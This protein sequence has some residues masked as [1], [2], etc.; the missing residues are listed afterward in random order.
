[1]SLFGDRETEK[2]VDSHLETL[3]SAQRWQVSIEERLQKIEKFLLAF[4]QPSVNVAWGYHV[5]TG[6]KVLITF[7]KDVDDET[8]ANMQEELREWFS[9]GIDVAVIAGASI[10]V[11][12]PD[13]S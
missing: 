2:H 12:R 6:D 1:M 5:Q 13:E 7:N 10:I 4:K 9:D 11:E 3:A 8:L